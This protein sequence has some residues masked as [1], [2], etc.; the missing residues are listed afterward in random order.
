MAG[1]LL[2]YGANGFTGQLIAARAKNLGYDV[3]L[4]GRSTD[5]LKSL[6]QLLE[7][8]WRVFGLDD[9]QHLDE[10]LVDVDAVLHLAGPFN[11]TAIP[12]LKACLR[13]VTHYLDVTGELG[14]FQALHRF[15]DEARSRGIMI[16]PGVGFVLLASDCLA[17]HVA[18][19]LPEAQYLRL[20]FSHPKFFSRGTLRTMLGLVREQVSIRREGRLTSVPVGRLERKFDYGEGQRVS[21]AV[22][23]ADV[24]TAY[25][26]TGIPNIEVYAEAPFMERGLYKIG[27]WFAEPMRL[28]SWQG[29]IDF[30]TRFWP[31]GPSSS[32]RAGA[33]RVI[34]AEA[35]DRWRRQIRSR[36]Y[37]P[38]GY[39]FTAV[40]ALEIG[41]R[42]LKGEYQPGYQTPASVYG[43][44]FVLSMDGVNREDLIEN[45]W[46]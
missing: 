34:V 9:P 14:V 25:Y 31:E 21:T 41:Q 8:P 23:W 44:D 46:A 15:D 26:T 32:A 12:M 10:A 6:A 45:S 2:I 43:P 40:S 27:A 42:V 19:K 30:Q 36:L 17:A 7:L 22:N 35:E 28:A 24:Y 38:D 33:K 20:G 13:K 37:T 29:I 3:V 4:A 5:R 16:M 1:R 39:D 18:S 11:V